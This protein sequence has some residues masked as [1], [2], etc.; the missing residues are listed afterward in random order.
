MHGAGHWMAFNA[1]NNGHTLVI[2]DEVT[3]LA[4]EAGALVLLDACQ[5]VGQLAID[6]RELG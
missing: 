2:Q 1:F 6:V 4:H 3:R 5:S